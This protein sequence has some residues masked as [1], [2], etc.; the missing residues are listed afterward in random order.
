METRLRVLSYRVTSVEDTED[1]L[2]SFA[3]EDILHRQAD[4]LCLQNLSSSSLWREKLST[5]GFASLWRQRTQSKA[6]HCTG[7]LIAYRRSEFLLFRSEEIEFNSALECVR[8]KSSSGDDFARSVG[9]LTSAEREFCVADEAALMALL[10]PSSKDGSS[11][12]LSASHALPLTSD[13]PPPA[14]T[15]SRVICS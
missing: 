11:A 9:E 2:Q 13:C 7:N 15:Y 4:I 10:Q 3:L 1:T 5:A 14:E 6:Y 8:R 12:L